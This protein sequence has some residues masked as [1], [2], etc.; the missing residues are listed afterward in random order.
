MMA[1][2]GFWVIEF[3]VTFNKIAFAWIQLN[4]PR[5]Q[6]SLKLIIFKAKSSEILM[7]RSFSLALVSYTVHNRS[8]SAYGRKKENQFYE[9]K[10]MTTTKFELH[11]N[12][13]REKER[14]SERRSNNWR[15]KR[16]WTFRIVNK[17][18]IH[19]NTLCWN[20][21]FFCSKVRLHWIGTW[22]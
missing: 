20:C 4:H 15:K 11:W 7:F 12:M 18:F 21:R 10:H 6:N 3:S 16:C 17:T 1:I 2:T 14:E 22:T 19:H 8:L 9:W 5:L 13:W